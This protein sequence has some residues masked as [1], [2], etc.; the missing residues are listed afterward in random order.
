MTKVKFKSGTNNLSTT[1]TELN[2]FILPDEEFLDKVT[3]SDPMEFTEEIAGITDE[4]AWYC[5]I[6]QMDFINQDVLLSHVEENHRIWNCALCNMTFMD[7]ESLREHV[8]ETHLLNKS[9]YLD[10]DLGLV[11]TKATYAC[12]ICVEEFNQKV[13]YESHMH[14]KH[15]ILLYQCSLCGKKI[16][17]STSFNRHTRSCGGESLYQCEFCSKSFKRRGYLRDHIKGVHEKKNSYFCHICGE[18]F[19]YRSRLMYHKRGEHGIGNPVPLSSKQAPEKIFTLPEEISGT[20]APDGA[21]SPPA[22]HMMMV[23]V[24][25]NGFVLN[26]DVA[27]EQ[28]NPEEGSSGTKPYSCEYCG[29]QYMKEGSYRSHLQRHIKGKYQCLHCDKEFVMKAS[30][31][32]HLRG[33]HKGEMFVCSVEDCK[34]S[35]QDKTSYNKHMKQHTERAPFTCEICGKP[36]WDKSRLESH[37]NTHYGIKPYECGKCGRKYSGSATLQRHLNFCGTDDRWGCEVCGKMFKCS[38]YLKDHMK[39]VHEKANT[40]L[41]SW[42]GGSF[43]RKCSLVRHLANCKQASSRDADLVVV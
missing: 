9:L 38:A 29:K 35:F 22:P 42:C 21:E 36:L 12:V 33:V 26:A 19:V 10:P 27:S 11:S 5:K 31:D 30:L 43:S 37:M 3:R 4:G 1:Q 15:N 25:D 41:C 24:D 28:L 16:A 7:E 18:S 40:F 8:E 2:Q 32:S 20:V 13:H 23:V 39:I 6:C 34:S 17:L 14:H